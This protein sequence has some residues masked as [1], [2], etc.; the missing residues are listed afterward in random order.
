MSGILN[1]KTGF[2]TGAANGIGKGIALEL[3]AEGAHVVVSDLASAEKDGL[4]VVD[5]IEKAGGRAVFVAADVTSQDDI[6]NLF[7]KTKALD[8]HLDFV[9]NNAGIGP[10]GEIAESDDKTYDLAMDIN[11]K[12]VFRVMRS[13]IRLFREQGKGGAILNISSVAGMTGLGTAGIYSASKHGIIG[14]TKTGAVEGG[15]DGI[16]VNA[17]LPN[18]I[19][20]KLLEGSSEEFLKLITE[21]QAIQRLGEPE[22]VGAAAA[23]LLSDKASFI[24]GASLPVDGGYLASN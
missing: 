20:S 17:I 23:F 5:M 8:G 12:S 11:L 7:D 1:G 6:D 22:E 9:V 14:F 24:T 13:A 15:K 18:A 3:A 10:K 2:V 16:R 19:K 21:P 4:A